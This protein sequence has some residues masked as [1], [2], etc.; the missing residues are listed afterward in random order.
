MK[1]KWRILKIL[2][3]VI[4]FGYLLNFSLNKFNNSSVNKMDVKLFSTENPV[5]FIDEGD[6]KSLV[7][8][9]TPTL[10]IGDLDIP[11]LEREINNMDV[12]DSANVYLNLNGILN[13]DIR[14]KTPKFR[15]NNK[16][17]NCYVDD[18]GN[19]FS[20]SKKYSHPCI[21]VTGNISPKEYKDVINC[22][23]IIEK[24]DF[25]KNY[26]IGIEKIKNNYYLL[27]ADGDF[28]VELGD[29]NN[30]DFKMKGFKV[31]LEKYLVF[32]EKSKYNKVSLKYNNQIVATLNK[33]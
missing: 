8:N 11:K 7:K 29:L 22:I 20:V 24:D 10:R 12:V 21:L 4:I 33:N 28:K 25:Y 5:F 2:V 9:I 6:V 27:T 3:T 18:K 26:F 30:M 1:N 13:I 14:Q 15:L 32:Q 19:E 23:H 17:K 16:T 31:F